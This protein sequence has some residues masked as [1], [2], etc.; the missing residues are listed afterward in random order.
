MKCPHCSVAVY[1]HFDV[2]ELLF[3]KDTNRKLNGWESLAG[4]CPNC[5]QAIIFLRSGPAIKDGYG[6][7]VFSGSRESFMV[8]PRGSVRPCPREVPIDIAK[9]F[10]EAVQ[11]LSISPQASAALTRRCLQHVLREFGKT[12]AKEL[13]DQ[14]QEVIGQGH[15]PPSLVEQLDAVRVIGNFAA[16]PL[17]S[18]TSGVIMPVEPNE[19]EWNLDVL[20]DVFDHYFVKPAQLQARKDALNKKLTEA[21]K[22]KLK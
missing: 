16:H 19:A 12:K 1:F 4:A 15:L 18:Q 20:E 9:D 10:S 11:V 8:W 21:N 7:I 2:K 17:K 5:E 14:I 3:S 13:F 6:N 22:A